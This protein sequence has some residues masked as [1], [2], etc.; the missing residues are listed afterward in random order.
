MADFFSVKIPQEHCINIRNLALNLGVPSESIVFE[1][2]DCSFGSMYVFIKFESIENL[3]K[4]LNDMVQLFH[5]Y[6]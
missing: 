6:L 5:I 4:F 2:N 1:I 3:Y